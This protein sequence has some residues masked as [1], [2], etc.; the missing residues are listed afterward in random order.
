VLFFGDGVLGA[1]LLGGLELG[2]CTLPGGARTSELGAKT[3]HFG[4]ER[5]R[6]DLEER[7]AA[8]DNGA[9]LE[10]YRGNQTGDARTD[11]DGIDRL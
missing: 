3:I 1:Q 8:S 5:A 2:R 4:L 11:F 7:I 10:P 9:F 6:V